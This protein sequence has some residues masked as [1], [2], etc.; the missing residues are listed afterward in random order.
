MQILCLGL[1]H[2]TAPVELREP[3]NYS[4]EALEAALAGFCE[5]AAQPAC[6]AE[7]V[8]LST[9]SRLEL[10]AAVQ[11]ADAA[12]DIQPDKREAL[13]APLLNFLAQTR[14][15]FA[16][17]L[18][19][20]FYRLIGPE[21][22]EHLGRVASGLDSMI[23]GEP[24]IL[25]QVGE[26]YSAALRH[27]SAGPVLSALFRS[28]IHAGKRSRAETGISRSVATLS[29][30]AVKLAENVVGPLA[31]RPVLIVGAGEVAESAAAALSSRG[32]AH[33]T[34]VNRTRARAVQLAERWG[35][36][37]LP[38]EQLGEALAAA[39]IVLTSTGAPHAVISFDAARAA[40]AAR[41]TRPLVLIDLAVPRDVEPAARRLPN[42]HYF[43]IDDIEAH[44][45]AA[46]A[47]RRQEVPRVEA[48]VAEETRAF[49]AWFANLEVTPL[50][51]DLR[52]KA[53]AIRRAE[54]DK[55]LRRLPAL[56]E[57][58]RRQIET[59]TEALVNKLLHDPTLRLK[60]E[61][62]LGQSS[63]YADAARY[64]FALDD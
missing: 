38:F 28:A 34:V 25:G 51:V 30:A 54:V 5:P 22:V 26:A 19:D 61:A 48:I 24:Q 13:F 33:I 14:G 3:L 42:T 49:L 10:Y 52:A 11:S 59:M 39:D 31:A 40:L 47:E 20:R 46:R 62:G 7:L 29:S 1:S 17:D 2:H 23:L 64:L 21:A 8:I 27:G 15:L 16:A 4:G 37:T 56:G 18:D 44:L 50:I 55:T 60:A 32:A 58:E 6:A 41:P 45:D 57:A 12:G 35:A 36:Q 53:E 43:D 63:E 9:C